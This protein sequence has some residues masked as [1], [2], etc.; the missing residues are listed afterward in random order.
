MLNEWEEF[1][2]YT[3]PV[4]YTATGKR[5]TT[6]LGRFTFDTLMDFEGLTRVL[7]IIARGYLFRHRDGSLADNPR[8]RT[9]HTRRALCAWCSIPDTKTAAPKAEWQFQTDFRGLH[10]E[11]P[12]LVD[13]SGGG[14]FWRHVHH[15]A[16]F[17]EANP[18]KVSKSAWNNSLKI[19]KRFDAAWRNKVQQF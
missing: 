2:Q 15:V 13:K 17:V 12:E 4:T 19:K 14:W 3:R 7:T 8:N 9:E 16:D 5:D 18:S 11:F 6:Y 10:E 1:L